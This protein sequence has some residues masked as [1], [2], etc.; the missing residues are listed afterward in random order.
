MM[1]LKTRSGG[2]LPGGYPFKDPRTAKTFNGMEADF[3]GQVHK[4]LQHRLQNPRV[5][6]PG[7]VGY[8]DTNSVAAELDAYQCQRLGN[9]ANHCSDGR[10]LAFDPPARER[11][12]TKECPRCQNLLIELLCPTCMSERIVGYRCAKCG[13]ATR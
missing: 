9:D 12:G 11:Q 3:H 6:P 5:Y 1:Y 10:P 4:I 2:F 8:L 7:E 13:Y